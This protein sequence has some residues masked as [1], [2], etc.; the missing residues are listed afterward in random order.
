MKISSSANEAGLHAFDGAT[1]ATPVRAEPPSSDAGFG[2]RPRSHHSSRY[3]P[4]HPNQS[5]RPRYAQQPQY[6][7]QSVAA[8]STPFHAG[9]QNDCS[10]HTIAAMTGWSEQ[11]V[12]QSLG[13]TQQ[14][15]RH[16]S[17]H[18][19]QPQDFTAALTHLN[20]NSNGTTVHHRQGSPGSLAASLPHLQ[21]G[22]QFA[23]GIERHAGLGH[24]VTARRAGF[25]LVVTD[26]QSG[27]Q[28]TF[29]SREDLQVYLDQSGAARVHTWY[30]Q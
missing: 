11:Q 9:T 16:I 20:G 10:L 26:R 12:V 6:A 4:Y 8:Q 30:N 19:M 5:K 21:D 2:A 23:L 15:I 14:Q 28:M 24:L 25:Q 1:S 18:G 29:N 3:H 17:A 27:Q 13:L 22:G 7:Q